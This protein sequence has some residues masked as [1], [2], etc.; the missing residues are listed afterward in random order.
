M[1]IF[2]LLKAGIVLNVALTHLVADPLLRLF[3]SET[4]TP[5]RAGIEL[6]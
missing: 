5:V 1:S 3:V 6:A 2:G 4:R